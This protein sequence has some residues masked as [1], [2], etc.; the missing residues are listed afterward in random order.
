MK[1]KNFLQQFLIGAVAI[2]II[3]YMILQLKLSVGDLVTVQTVELA[4]YEETFEV[5]GY[6][7]RNEKVIG[8]STNGEISYLVRDNQK[9]AA[10]TRVLAVY[11][12]V[13]DAKKQNQINALKNKIAI[14]EKSSSA[15]SLDLN[16]I[17]DQINVLT[18]QSIQKIEANDLAGAI[19]N[20]GDLLILQ[21]RKQAIKGIV[22]FATLKQALE[23]EVTYLENSMSGQKTI[24]KADRAGYFYSNVDG[25]E[26]VFLPSA[27]D[28]MSLE[29]FDALVSSQP[30]LIVSNTAVGKIVYD[31]KW[32]FI[33]KM[34]KRIVNSFS[35]GKAYEFDYLH[36]NNMRIPMVFNRAVIRTDSEE[37]IAIFHSQTMPEDFGFKREQPVNIVLKAYQGL[38]VPTDAIRRRGGENGVYIV[39]GNIVSF[40]KVEILFERRGSFIC[41]LQDEEN[42]AFVSQTHLSLYDMVIVGGKNMYHGKV[43]K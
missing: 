7:I 35:K 31:S 12:D 14:L 3:A 18:L 8:S 10:D 42:K 2:M 26:S 22:D 15:L 16:S 41:K 6:I 38:E 29:N 43:L 9:V 23:H 19:F 27:L 24:V 25:Y 34:D 39:K 17:E 21:N 1:Q 11:S 40:R 13:E 32:Y 5:T 36:T 37:A 28:N 33:C 4:S 30:N 20:S